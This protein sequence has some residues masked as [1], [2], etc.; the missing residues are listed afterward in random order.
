MTTHTTTTLATL[1]D[2]TEVQTTVTVRRPTERPAC[3]ARTRGPGLRRCDVIETEGH[4]VATVIPLR[5][6][7]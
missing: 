1:P 3:G 7:S 2:G 4:E 5:R 6:A